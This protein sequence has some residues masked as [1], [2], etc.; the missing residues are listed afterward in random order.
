MKCPGCGNEAARLYP[1]GCETCHEINR[2]AGVHTYAERDAKLR[3][4]LTRVEDNKPKPKPTVV[5]PPEQR[6]NPMRTQIRWT[7]EECGQVAAEVERLFPGMPF[8][9]KKIKQAQLCLPAERRKLNIDGP[10]VKKVRALIPGAKSPGPG[11]A[12]RSSKA[13]ARVSRRR[14]ATSAPVLFQPAADVLSTSGSL[15]DLIAQQLAGAVIGIGIQAL[16]NAAGRLRSV[17]A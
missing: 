16:E 5:P 1:D 17:T 7:P 15:P 2:K 14:P 11:S 13:I 10:S 6:K 8:A 9:A 3:A 12:R 4:S